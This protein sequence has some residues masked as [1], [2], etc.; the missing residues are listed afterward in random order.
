[1]A[2]KFTQPQ[3]KKVKDDSFTVIAFKE[4]K[5]NYTYGNISYKQAMEEVIKQQIEGKVCLI[6]PG[7]NTFSIKG[8]EIR[9]W[10]EEEHTLDYYLKCI[11]ADKENAGEKYLEVTNTH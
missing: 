9:Q 11:Q 4:G 8:L 1:M 5:H 7:G 3:W 10:K 6:I 2:A